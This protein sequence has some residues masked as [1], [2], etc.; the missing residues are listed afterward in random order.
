MTQPLTFCGGLAS[1]NAYLVD[2]NGH[3]L[4][5]DAPEGFL[6]FLKKKKIKPHSLFLTHGHWDHIWDAADLAL[7][8]TIPI[9]PTSA[10]NPTR[11]SPSACPNA[12]ALSKPPSF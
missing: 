5:I 12:S 8:I 10:F 2:L 7:F 9:P 11:C 1:T 4:A 6:D 3:L